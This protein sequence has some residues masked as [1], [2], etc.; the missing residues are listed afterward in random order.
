MSVQSPFC[1]LNDQVWIDKFEIKSRQTFV[2]LN[3]LQK[4]K[5]NLISDQQKLQLHSRQRYH[6]V[7]FTDKR[8]LVLSVLLLL[9]DGCNA[10]NN[11]VVG[12]DPSRIDG[13][14]FLHGNDAF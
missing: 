4:E 13:T 12:N 8:F 14:E 5:Y 1:R 7:L 11:N 10:G 6:Y 2:A 9:E 3:W